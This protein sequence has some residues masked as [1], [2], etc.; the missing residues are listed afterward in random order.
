MS[1]GGS[2]AAL[3]VDSEVD[4]PLP[5]GV[6]HLLVANDALIPGRWGVHVALCGARRRAPEPTALEHECADAS[7]D[8][9]HYCP[10]CVQEAARW[11]AEPVGQAARAP[12]AP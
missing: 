3:T 8:C 4:A 12:E 10:D 9:V 5:A 11:S 6:S 7:C 2:R 1:G